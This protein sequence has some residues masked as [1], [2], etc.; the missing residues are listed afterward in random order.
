MTTKKNIRKRFQKE[1]KYAAY[2]SCFKSNIFPPLL[3]LYQ[4][5]LCLVLLEIMKVDTCFPNS[6]NFSQTRNILIYNTEHICCDDSC[7]NYLTLDYFKA[8][9]ILSHNCVFCVEKNF[10]WDCQGLSSSPSILGHLFYP[11]LQLQNISVTEVEN[12]WNYG[13]CCFVL[14]PQSEVLKLHLKISGSDLCLQ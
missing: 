9:P 2:D 12:L 11:E 13:L 14:Q 7:N 6:F 5:S 1:G 3:N 8:A 10:W 4:F